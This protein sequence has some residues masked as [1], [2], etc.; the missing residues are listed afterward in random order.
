M[1][2]KK[3]FFLL[4][5]TIISIAT[6]GQFLKSPDDSKI[7]VS[8][9]GGYVQSEIK[10]SYVDY[11]LG[12][13]LGGN[14]PELSGRDG[15]EIEA[16]VNFKIYRCFYAKTG[17]GYNEQGGEIKYNDLVHPI[18]IT[19]RYLHLPVSVGVYLLT[20]NKLTVASEGGLQ[21]NQEIS[22]DLDFKNGTL[23]ENW[24]KTFIPAYTYRVLVQYRINQKLSVQG[25]YKYMDSLTPFYEEEYFTGRN[26]MSTEAK[27]YSLGLVLS[28][29]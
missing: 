23:N 9:S 19:L 22:S 8:F 6:Q 12:H 2:V 18:D 20:L 4:F 5:A 14:K 16:I 15:M 11:H 1:T 10:G 24:S 3:F 27:S 7:H 26:G 25:S 13:Y 28:M 17:L 21:L 29:R